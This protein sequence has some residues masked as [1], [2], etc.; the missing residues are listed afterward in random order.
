MLD[1]SKAEAKQPSQEKSDENSNYEPDDDSDV[2]TEED[3]DDDAAKKK[4]RTPT[5][6][7]SPKRM[8][9]TVSP[10]RS[11]TESTASDR[12][13][14]HNKKKTCPLTDC[15]FYGNDLKRH[16][17]VHVKKGHLAEEAV[18]R[19]LSTIRAG[20]ESR[21]KTRTKKGKQPAKATRR[22]G[23]QCLAATNSFRTWHA[24]WK[25]QKCMGLHEARNCT[26]GS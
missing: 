25:I 6:P 19:M 26:H 2:S 24:T 5:S 9:Q 1:R 4:T 14:S 7:P 3:T 22:S 12:P 21:G 20:A 18:D 23:V 15:S 8:K 17:G 10:P 11:P 16:L 13:R